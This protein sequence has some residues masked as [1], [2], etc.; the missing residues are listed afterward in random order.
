[1]STRINHLA[2][3]ILVIVH[4]AIGFGWYAAF[5]NVWLNYHAKTMTDIEQPTDFM[6]YAIA[7]AAS[8]FVN[9]G[10]ARLMS[11]F[12]ATSAI[13]GLKIA[14]GCWFAF[15]FVE[16]AAV[17]VFS[18]FGTNPWPLILIDMGRPFVAFAVSGLVLGAWPKRAPI[19][20]GQ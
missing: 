18:A 13:C 10:L 5:G 14:L 12:E 7:I 11:V 1:M 6:P 20:T 9:Y 3:W 2:V 15:L 19:A 17:S 16:H 4:Q 8:I